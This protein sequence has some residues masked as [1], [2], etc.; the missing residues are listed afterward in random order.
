MTPDNS[1]P[2]TLG[3]AF[4]NGVYLGRE[5]NAETLHDLRILT[6]AIKE[7]IE[8]MQLPNIDMLVHPDGGLT[9]SGPQRT[10]HKV[11]NYVRQTRDDLVV[12]V[13]SWR[14]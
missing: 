12:L 5:R 3:I 11:M 2:A 1:A 8:R 9:L 4:S 10:L 13:T 14:P 7:D 6:K